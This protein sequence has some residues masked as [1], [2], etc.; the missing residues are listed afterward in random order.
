[1]PRV[2]F[3]DGLGL[4]KR[5]PVGGLVQRPPPALLMHDPLAA[6]VLSV[7]GKKK[8]LCASCMA[9]IC[10]AQHSSDTLAL[11]SNR[12]HTL[13]KCCARLCILCATRKADAACHIL[14]RRKGRE[15]ERGKAQKIL[16]PRGPDMEPEKGVIS[17][18]YPS[19]ICYEGKP[20]Q[21]IN[22]HN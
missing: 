2:R 18:R 7:I 3:C 1:M 16:W 9:E 15:R 12:T 19:N 8:M 10:C 6:M 4:P 5:D 22:H 11:R 17:K 13:P 21:Y 14:Q 20:V